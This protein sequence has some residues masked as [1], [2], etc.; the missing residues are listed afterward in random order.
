MT[1]KS[2]ALAFALAAFIGGALPVEPAHAEI[3]TYNL[4]A[5]ADF[6][7][8]FAE[9]MKPYV[10]GRDATFEWWNAEVGAKIGVRL[11]HKTYDMRYDAAQAATL[12]PGAK[13]ELNPIAV[14]GIGG[15]DVSALKE[16]LPGDRVPMLLASGATGFIWQPNQWI[17]FTRPTYSHET[18]AL[19]DWLHSKRNPAA[20]LRVAMVITE[21][22]PAF[23]D[24]WRGIESWGKATGK[25]EIVDVVRTDP[26]PTDLTAQMRTVVGK[27]ADV[28]AGA[29]SIAMVVAVKRGLQ[30]MGAKIPLL[31]GSQNSL[32][33]AG[34]VLGGMDQVEGDYESYAMA[35]PATDGPAY[36]FYMKLQQQYRLQAPWSPLVAMGLTHAMFTGRAVEAAVAKVGADKLTGAAIYEAL[37]A[38][39]IRSQD[40]FGLTSDLIFD[41]SAPFPQKGMT[42]NIGMISGGK[43]AVQAT[44]VPVP[45]IPKW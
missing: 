29:S 4:A 24:L 5:M 28:I 44:G 13:S 14:L 16:R 38:T 8:P 3:K 30:A 6:S 45:A 18:V 20:P 32:V 40:T 1:G 2:T 9:A 25:I 43:Y 41:H 19:L 34:R 42:V 31:L 35:L 26:Q 36:A 39:P 23:V 7:G 10:A 22:S 17:F 11:A 37:L 21:A 12:W 33:Y 15:P 27:K